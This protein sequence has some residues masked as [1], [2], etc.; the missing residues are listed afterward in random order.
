[1][2]LTKPNFKLTNKF[3]SSCL[4]GYIETSYADLVACFGEPNCDGDGY[5]VD[6]EWM[7]KFNN[8]VYATIYNYKTGKNYLGDEGQAVEDITTW[9]VGG[10]SIKAVQN[11]EQAMS[12]YLSQVCIEQP[13]LSV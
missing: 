10:M 12:D 1:M 6:A 13:K 3:E 9:H 11:V 7:V 2:Q 5:K 4:Q 8:G